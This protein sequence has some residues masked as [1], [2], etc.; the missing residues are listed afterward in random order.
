MSTI[1]ESQTQ[2]AE[3]EWFDNW[4]R[5]PTNLRWKELPIQVGDPA[6][7]LKMLDSSGRYVKLSDYWSSGP[8]LLVFLRH[9]GCSCARDRV[10]NLQNE[11]ADYIGAGASVVLISQGEPE[12]AAVFGEKYGAP[13]PILCDPDYQAY[14]AYGLLDGKP[15]QVAY[16]TSDELLRRDYGAAL[17]VAS[18]YREAGHPLVDSPWQLPGEFVIDRKGVVQLAWRYQYCADFAEPLVL[19]AAIQE[20]RWRIDN[21]L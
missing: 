11:Y 12:R 21:K 4:E 19:L 9:F 8:A 7:D 18:A 17:E 2:A 16:G 1:T 5:G 20:A 13:C 14:N 6:P 3:E 15:S 10:V